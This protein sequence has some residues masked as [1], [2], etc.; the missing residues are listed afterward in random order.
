MVLAL[1]AGI[2]VA[3]ACGLRAFLPL[4]IL[5]GAGRFGFVELHPS[6]SWLAHDPALIAL[7]VATVLEILGDKI[8]AVDHALDAVGTL[9]RPAAGFLAGFALLVHWPEPWGALIALIL[10]GGTLAVHALKSKVRLG[11]TLTTLGLGNPVLSVIEDFTVAGLVI[12]AILVPLI[13]LLTMIATIMVVV[14]MRR[15]ETPVPRDLSA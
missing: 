2:G 11:S 10:G 13:M 8:P 3:A 6:V 7:T 9:L 4:L 15:R 5:G 1:A 14:R 12:L